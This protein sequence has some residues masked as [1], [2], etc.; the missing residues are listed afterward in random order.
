MRGIL[1]SYVSFRIGYFSY[2][3]Y[4]VSD[5]VELLYEAGLTSKGCMA[6]KECSWL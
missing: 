2:K 3:I 1:F 6:I 5:R 4:I